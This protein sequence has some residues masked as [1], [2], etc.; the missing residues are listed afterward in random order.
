VR[1]RDILV[2]LSL[3]AQYI[4]NVVHLSQYQGLRHSWRQVPPYLKVKVT[5]M[6]VW[7]LVERSS[8]RETDRSLL[9]HEIRCIFRHPN[10]RCRVHNTLLLVFVMSQTNP[11]HGFPLTHSHVYIRYILT[12][13]S[14]LRLDLPC[15]LFHEDYLP[16]VC[17]QFLDACYCACHAS[18]I[19]CLF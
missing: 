8:Y 5:N 18:F 6:L 15:G 17:M 4:C 9:S 7:C 12:L 13:S 16:G 11:F 10:V 1:E 14:H 19:L 3:S 2:S